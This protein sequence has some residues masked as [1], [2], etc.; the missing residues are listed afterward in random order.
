MSLPLRAAESQSYLAQLAGLVRLSLVQLIHVPAHPRRNVATQQML[1][2]LSWQLSWLLAIG[3]VVIVVLMFGFDATEIGWMPPRGT[4][5]LWPVRILTDFGRDVD[6]LGILAG[7]LLVIALA[8]PLSRWAGAR[9]RLLRLG[10][11]VE[12]LLL[13][14]S[15]PVAIAEIVKWVVGRGRPFVGGKANAFNFVPFNGTEAH[16]SFPSAHAV[17]AFALAYGVAAIWPRTRLVMAFYAVTIAMTRLVLLAHHPS[18]VVAGAVMGVTGATCVRAWFAAHR[19]GF[20]IH[21]NGEI[22]SR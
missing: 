8:L 14:V 9:Y 12:Y 17:T 18:D 13:A 4:P 11:D 16:F 6:V 19:L 2:Q 3:A 15:V 5:G 20:V 22:A 21:P 1:R 7:L 10:I